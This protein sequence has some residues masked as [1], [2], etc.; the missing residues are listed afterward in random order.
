M[1]RRHFLLS[2]AVLAGGLYVESYA[3]ADKKLSVGEGIGVGI[4]GAGDRGSGIANILKK[5]DGIQVVAVCDLLPFRID[6]I[7]QYVNSTTAAYSN[8]Q[9]LLQDPRVDAVIVTVPYTVHFEVAMAALAAGKHVYCEK[10]LTHS[11]DTAKKLVAKA[12]Q[13]KS[14]FQSGH[15]FRS[16]PMHIQVATLIEQGAI[17]T[18]THMEHQWNRSS[19]WRRPVSDPALE[20]IINWRLYHESS[21][22]LMAELCSHHVDFSNWLLGGHVLKVSG[23]GSVNYWK[24]GRETDDNIHVTAEYPNGVIVS[25]SSL[26]SNSKGGLSSAIFGDKGTIVLNAEGVW[27]HKKDVSTKELGIVDG[28]A[29]A[30]LHKN[31]WEQGIPIPVNRRDA[32]EQALEDFRN[33]ILTG[34]QPKSTVKTGAEVA[35]TVAMALNAMKHNRVEYWSKRYDV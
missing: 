31:N 30:T 7:R 5:I 32:T 17:G 26:L 10:T 34:V 6:A 18:I 14:I 23:M 19:D 24:D 1:K 16:S 35:I 29:G 12:N 13:S 2:G 20:K 8:Y 9:E 33:S 25:F 28:V 4:V 27:L 15:Q 3:S 11:I 21:G 22:G